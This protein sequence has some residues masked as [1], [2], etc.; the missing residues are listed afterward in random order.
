MNL[1]NRIKKLESVHAFEPKIMV[2]KF[3]NEINQLSCEGNKFQRQ[4][5]ELEH[6][7]IERVKLT[8]EQRPNKPLI[9]LLIANF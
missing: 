2:V 9:T 7:F 6:E 3:G 8:L 5:N 4:E 1:E